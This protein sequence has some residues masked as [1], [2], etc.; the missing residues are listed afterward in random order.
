MLDI[1]VNGIRLSNGENKICFTKIG[2]FFSSRFIQ[3]CEYVI[4]LAR[5]KACVHMFGWNENVYRKKNMPKDACKYICVLE[6]NN[7]FDCHDDKIKMMNQS[8]E[9]RTEKKSEFYVLF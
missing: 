4:I 9:N 8:T 1:L 3:T 7:W 2:A 6:V 5:S